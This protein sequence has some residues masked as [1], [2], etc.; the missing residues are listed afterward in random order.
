M[1]AFKHCKIIIL[2][3]LHN[4]PL[5]NQPKFVDLTSQSHFLLKRGYDLYRVD[6]TGVLT[7]RQEL[8]KPFKYR[9]GPYVGFA[10][11]FL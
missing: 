2:L 3:F 7:S 11:R 1:V 6:G 9:R 10:S 8:S 4:L 5:F